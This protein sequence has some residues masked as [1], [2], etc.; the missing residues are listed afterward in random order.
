[1][2]TLKALD[3]KFGLTPSRTAYY[4]SD[5][6]WWNP[7]KATFAQ[8]VNDWRLLHIDIDG[9]GIHASYPA[10]RRIKKEAALIIV[11][12]DHY[13]ACSGKLEGFP[14]QHIDA[15]SFHISVYVVRRVGPQADDNRQG[16]FEPVPP[17]EFPI[18]LQ[19]SLG[20]G[21]YEGVKFPARAN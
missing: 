17:E 20:I 1:M 16:P 7:G 18:G 19:R 10:T 5:P 3:A 8:L 13:N 15:D 12:A 21:A 14:M 11:A 4:G 2:A 6:H 9:N